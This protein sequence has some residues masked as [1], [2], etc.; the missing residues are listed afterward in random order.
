MKATEA[1]FDGL[2]GLTHH[3][4]GLSFG[5]EASTRNQLQPSNPRLAAKQG[6]LKMKALADMGYVQGVIPPHE[7]PN[8]AALRQLGFGGSDE[9][10]LAAAGKTAPGLLSA[11]SSASAMWVAN[12]ATVSPSADSL[13]GR[14][15]LTV[16]NLNNKFHRAIEAP[17]T[18]W[19]LRSIF[20]D[21]RHFAVHDAL[22]QVA[23]FGDEGAANHNRLGGAYGERGVQ[24]FVYG[25]DSSHEG[26]APQR[27][28]AR[29]TREASEAVAR[30]HQL[31]PESVL[32]AQQNPA[33]IDQGVF[34]NDVIAVSNQQMLFCHQ[35][36]FVNQPELLAQLRSRV[37]GFV[38]LEVPENRVSV[39]DA[40][41]TYLFNSQL[42]SRPDGTMMLVLPEESRQHPGVWRYLCEQVE[43]DTPLKAL[44]VFDLRESMYNGGGPACLRLRVVLTPQEQQ[45]V[46][47][48]VLMNDRLF[49]T[50][51][52]WVDRHYRDRLTQADLVDPQL[53]REGRDA[54]DELTKL[55]DLG[56]VYAFQQ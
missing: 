18:A 17:E 28:P 21:D 24:L 2:V 45:A 43:A 49:S 6:L 33:V 15:H 35:H 3:Y 31:S 46:N 54:L 12:A 13:D 7:R 32:Y 19:L 50:L 41:E 10:V 55:L 38:A 16:A 27:Y 42:L 48:A 5:N 26:K 51:N 40:V 47:P 20:R 44:K 11:V 22:P 34:H 29:Q 39:K 37:P 52:N 23:M 8:I 25:R 30:L 36:A 9:Q 4:A 1:N 53:L 14:V 56:N